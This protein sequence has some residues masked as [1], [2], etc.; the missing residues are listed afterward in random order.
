[1]MVTVLPCDGIV[2]GTT[3]CLHVIAEIHEIR[4]TSSVFG[5]K[6]NLRRLPA[7]KRRHESPA[8]GAAARAPARAAAAGPTVAATSSSSAAS[9]L[10]MVW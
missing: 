3:K 1:M 2:P 5:F 7:G 8:S 9:I 10:P 6:F 4:S